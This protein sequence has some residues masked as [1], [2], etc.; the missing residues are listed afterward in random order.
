VYSDAATVAGE[1]AS[2]DSFDPRQR[3]SIRRGLVAR[4]EAN[5]TALTAAG[6][7]VPV[8]QITRII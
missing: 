1:R 5:A 3:V 2:I 6:G 8:T 4:A 7:A